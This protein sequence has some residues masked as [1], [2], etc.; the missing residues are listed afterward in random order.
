MMEKAGKRHL[1]LALVLLILY[2]LLMFFEKT[3]ILNKNVPPFFL[4][5]LYLAA[6]LILVALAVNF[7]NSAVHRIKPSHFTESLLQP[8]Y[9]YYLLL[10]TILCGGLQLLVIWLQIKGYIGDSS[11]QMKIEKINGFRLWSFRIFYVA[12]LPVIQQNLFNGLVFNELLP[13]NNFG[14]HLA[15]LLLIALLTGLMSGQGPSFILGFQMLLGLLMGWSYLRARNIGT[16]ITINI[17][18]NLIFVILYS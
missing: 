18:C 6:G 8:P 14:S 12:F 11:L 2:G 16:P 9:Y 13:K 4:L 5:S 10:F 17:I 3:I 1:P 7:Y 15:G